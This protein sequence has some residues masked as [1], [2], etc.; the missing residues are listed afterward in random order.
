MRIDNMLISVI[1]A[2]VLAAV[3]QIT[4]HIAILPEKKLKL[5]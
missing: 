5:Y 4:K 1:V 2:A 3:D